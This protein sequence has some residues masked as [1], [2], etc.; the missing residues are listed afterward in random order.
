VTK[1]VRVLSFLVH[2]KQFQIRNCKAPLVMK[3]ILVMK[4]CGA[5]VHFLV[6][7][8]RNLFLPF[9]HRHGNIELEGRTRSLEVEV[10]DFPIS[11]LHSDLQGYI[12]GMLPLRKL[13]QIAHLSKSV[14]KMYLE[15]VKERDAHVADL[16]E[17]YFTA[18]FRE[19]LSPADTR[20]PRDLIVDLR[21]RKWTSNFPGIFGGK[22]VDRL[23][24]SL[25]CSGADL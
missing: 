21:V 15:R 12:L 8:G 25:V 23:F 20:L 4:C 5:V 9:K 13:A 3:L 14:H 7:V 10:F 11:D 2:H 24:P 17:S 16:M 18:E 1:G 19:G 6:G 22:L